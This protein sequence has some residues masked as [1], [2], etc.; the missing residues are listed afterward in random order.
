MSAGGNSLKSILF[1]LGANFLI[2]I[3]KTAG[4][5]FTG[6][7]SM[8]AEAIHSYADCAN[9]GLLLWGLREGRR[10]ANADH[11]LG[12]GKALY[13][14]SF[15]VAL[16]LFSMGGVFSIYE[17]L[18]KWSAPQPMANAW[19]A[20]A[21]LVFGIVAET[22]SLWGCLREVNKERGRQGLWRWFRSSRQ[23]ELLVVFAE[24]IAALG[25]LALALIFIAIALATGNPEWDA[26]G[27]ICIGVLLVLVAGFVGV[28][29]KA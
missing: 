21:I 11:P 8:L 4:A 20:I 24:D 17:G 26:A 27:S 13:F 9:Q 7:S 16:M 28:E 14:W 22:F 2:A 6:S 18:H 19:V 10:P 5:V 23:S 3:A 15:I 12:Y 25:G 29:I 1:A